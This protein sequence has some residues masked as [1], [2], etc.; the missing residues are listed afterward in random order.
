MGEDLQREFMFGLKM[1]IL[2]CK[3]LD[4]MFR[5]LPQLSECSS[6]PVCYIYSTGNN[7]W[8]HAG[9][10]PMPYEWNGNETSPLPG[11]HYNT[12]EDGAVIMLLV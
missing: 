7:K 9:H 11:P 5:T 12:S 6:S 8:E 3:I 1:F 2:Q 4:M 10:I